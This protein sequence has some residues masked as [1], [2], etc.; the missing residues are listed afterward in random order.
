M[1]SSLPE[2]SESDIQRTIVQWSKMVPGLRLWR[3]RSAEAG[4]SGKGA[5]RSR[6]GSPDLE[7][8]YTTNGVAVYVG[9]EVKAKK[10]KVSDA[11]VRW[12]ELITT[13]GGIYVLARDLQDVIDVFA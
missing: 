2:P 5:D 1:P 9:I 13:A 11:Q 4:R 6:T 8:W 10:G 3:N 7:G 12:G